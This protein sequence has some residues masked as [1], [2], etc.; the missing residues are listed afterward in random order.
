MF[1]S[2]WFYVVFSGDNIVSVNCL[3]L[4]VSFRYRIMSN[5]SG[6]RPNGYSV[7]WIRAK[8][9]HVL[10]IMSFMAVSSGGST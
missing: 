9:C 8:S 7:S 4:G 2:N 6:E 5:S 3:T 1:N 10:C